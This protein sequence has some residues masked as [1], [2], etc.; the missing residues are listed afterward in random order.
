MSIKEG[1]RIDEGDDV[2]LGLTLI[3]HRLSYWMISNRVF[4]EFS[5]YVQGLL[6]L[7]YR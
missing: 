7:S 5:A 1:S 3:V 6:A 4:F 2:Q